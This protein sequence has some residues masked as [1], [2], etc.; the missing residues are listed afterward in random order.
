MHCSA[1]VMHWNWH[2]YYANIT[3][4]QEGMDGCFQRDLDSD[5]NPNLDQFVSAQCTTHWSS[6]GWQFKDTN[7]PGGCFKHDFDQIDQIVSAQHSTH[8]SC[9]GWHSAKEYLQATLGQSQPVPDTDPWSLI[10][11]MKSV[12]RLHLGSLILILV[13]I[14]ILIFDIYSILSHPGHALVGSFPASALGESGW[15]TAAVSGSHL[16]MH[17]KRICAKR[18]KFCLH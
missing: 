11:L 17:C 4:E 9:I 12:C 7:I 2:L 5:W 10:L 1:L 13:L 8:W 18:F 15:P 3:G 6:I 16:C 14:L